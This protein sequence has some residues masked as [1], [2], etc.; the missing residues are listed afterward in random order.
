M[1]DLLRQIRE[2]ERRV[3]AL[4]AQE[5]GGLWV[6]WTPTLTQVNSITVSI[7]YAQYC[8]NGKHVLVRAKLSA[9][10]A[11]VANNGISIGNIPAAIAPAVYGEPAIVA[12][13]FTYYDAGTAYYVGNIY[14]VSATQF[15]MMVH[16]NA[17]GVVGQL[18]N[19]AVANGDALGFIG[20]YRIA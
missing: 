7:L 2:L 19:F 13:N 5:V 18:P 3:G 12:G 6:D 14:A 8:T 10:T 16:N 1:E 4:E 20:S 9:S 15:Y 11:G 17:G